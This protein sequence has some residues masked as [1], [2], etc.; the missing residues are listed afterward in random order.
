M[1]EQMGGG[2]A[3]I[4]KETEEG[5]LRLDNRT[6]RGAEAKGRDVEWRQEKLEVG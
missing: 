4:L 5:G 6:Q 2:R 1:K 3:E